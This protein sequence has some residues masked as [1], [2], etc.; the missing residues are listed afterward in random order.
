MQSI[1]VAVYSAD[2]GTAL[3][4]LAS[5]VRVHIPLSGETLSLDGRGKC[6]SGCVRVAITVGLA[7][8]DGLE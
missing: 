1:A 3:S 4:A 6:R 5:E 2:T 8:E 7:Q